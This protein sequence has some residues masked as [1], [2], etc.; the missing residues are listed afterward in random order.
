MIDA[1]EILENMRVQMEEYKK[2]YIDLGTEIEAVGKEYQSKIDALQQ[3]RLKLAEEG[4]AKLDQLKLKREQISGMHAGL[5][6]QYNKFTSKADTEGVVGADVKESDEKQT[7]TKTDKPKSSETK[8]KNTTKQTT[9]TQG[10]SEAEKETLAKIVAKKPDN[11]DDKGN[12]IP[13]YLQ[14]E[15]NN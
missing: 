4:N 3:E 9:Q 8:K 15:Y 2:Q 14:S 6:A 7:R 13:D 11:K 10:L 12:V 5:Y 1:N